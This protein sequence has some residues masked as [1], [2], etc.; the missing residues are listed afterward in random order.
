[1]LTSEKFSVIAEMENGLEVIKKLKYSVEK[2]D[3]I[4]MDIDMP[5]KDGLETIKE[6]RPEYPNIKIVVVT[7]HN[8]EKL[9]NELIKLK[10]EAFILKPFDRNQVVQKLAKVL[11]RQ[12]LLDKVATGYTNT[13]T[14][15]LNEM[16]IPALPHVVMKVMTFDTSNPTGG[17]Q[18][19]EQ[20]ISPDKSITTT[21]LRVAN[22]AFYGRSG[23]VKTVKDAITLIG[24]KTV[25][26]LVILQSV[27][28]TQKL[29]PGEVFSKYLKELPILT[30]LIAFDIATPFG[31]KTIRDEAFLSALLYKIGMT[32][33]AINFK[34]RYA[35]VINASEKQLKE[36][37]LIEKNEFKIS[38]VELGLKVFKAWNMPETMKS[39]I[40]KQGFS[41][42]EIGEVTDLNRLTRVSEALAKKMIGIYLNPVEEKIVSEVIK[43]YGEE[44]ETISEIFGEDYYEMIQDHPF[45]EITMKV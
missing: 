38:S 20:I 22:S 16:K 32:I 2:P 25:K 4:F 33:L 24:V 36:L 23:G 15:N 9:I 27:K 6:V 31:L 17:S 44:E 28:N 26:N 7:M 5:V 45:F 39:V 14:L 43:H 42:H 8:H 34:D 3:L 21:L 35:K 10:V 30:A 41:P 12:D 29:A 18:E 40:E 37:I 13:A 19:L 1:M 11:G